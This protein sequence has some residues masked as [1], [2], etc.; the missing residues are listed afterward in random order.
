M[1]DLKKIDFGLLFEG[2]GKFYIENQ[3]FVT[4]LR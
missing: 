1:Y 4:F 2:L 3:H